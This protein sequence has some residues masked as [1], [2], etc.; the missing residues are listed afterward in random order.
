M[1][2]R[3]ELIDDC[4]VYSD[5]LY[6]ELQARANQM[7]E[8]TS[9]E[10][11]AKESIEISQSEEPED[12]WEFLEKYDELFKRVRLDMILDHGNAIPPEDFIARARGVVSQNMCDK[13]F[14]AESLDAPKLKNTAK[15]FE[16][17]QLNWSEAAWKLLTTPKIPLK[18]YAR[19]PELRNIP[20]D[21]TPFKGT[22][23]HQIG[24]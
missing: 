4:I 12:F 13:P 11:A 8:T 17:N 21:I 2:V 3:Y 15:Q 16:R 19:P 1:K 10:A 23:T 22:N 24:G 18:S 5:K 14:S 9:P 20:L 7:D 6:T